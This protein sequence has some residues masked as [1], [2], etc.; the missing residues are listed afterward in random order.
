MGRVHNI[1]RDGT[2]K[3]SYKRQVA[4]LQAENKRLKEENRWIPISER[5]PE[6]KKVNE[7]DTFQSDWVLITDGKCWVEAYYYD[8]TK[9]EAK[10]NYA[11]GKGWYC[12]GIY[13]EEITHWT[14]IILPE[15]TLKDK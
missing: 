10:P 6:L 13:K 3:S 2:P 12:Q 15:Q 1:G 8:Y 11:T 4:E 9:R 14:P 7:K 5:L